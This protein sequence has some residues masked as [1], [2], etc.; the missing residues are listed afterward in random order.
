MSDL[1][2]NRGVQIDLDAK[3]ARKH[4]MYMGQRTIVELPIA[5]SA[6]SADGFKAR[7]DWSNVRIDVV[8]VTI[9][10][11]NG[12]AAHVPVVDGDVTKANRLAV[13]GTSDFLFASPGLVVRRVDPIANLSTLLELR[14]QAQQTIQF[15]T[16]GRTAN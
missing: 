9:T 7:I 10:D 8:G 11:G 12:I 2:G 14:R 15:A 6:R 5:Q 1:I 4:D 13:L 16:R 3:G